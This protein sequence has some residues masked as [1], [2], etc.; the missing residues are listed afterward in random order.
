MSR[1]AALLAASTIVTC[2]FAATPASAQL[3]IDRLWV[4]FEPG[5][6]KRADIV[7]RNE[8]QDR[9]YITVAPVEIST[10]GAEVEQREQ[11]ADPEALGLLV[12]P[13]RLI[14]EPGGM[15][16]IR[17]V[18]LN[19][20]LAKDR[21]YRV[22]VS[23]EVGAIETADPGAEARGV[24]VKLLTAYDLL[25]TARPEKGVS[26]LATR[27]D[28]DGFTITNEGNTNTLLF[29]GWACPAGARPRSPDEQAGS[30]ASATASACTEIGARRL[31][32][33]NSWTFALPQGTERI[34]FKERNLASA[35]PR[36]V[37]F[38]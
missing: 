24:S 13:N 15:R 36:E 1:T 32:A 2:A 19:E 29:E 23:P 26:K 18:S 11:I 27:R 34:V 3:A 20:K 12:S 38:R 21:I 10:P 31:Y 8:S 14:V 25:V 16:S 28:A 30:A 33:G 17:L 35:E 37:E 7:I 5:A 6:A 9:Y 4:D 22:R